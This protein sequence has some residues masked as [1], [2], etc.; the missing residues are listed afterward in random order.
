MPTHA[1][2]RFVPFRPEQIYD[3]V[4]DVARRFETHQHAPPKDTPV[5]AAPEEGG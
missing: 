3:L 4:A 5:A 1:E 2:R